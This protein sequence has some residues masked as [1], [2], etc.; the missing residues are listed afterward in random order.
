MT[1]SLLAITSLAV[2]VLLI[3][4]FLVYPTCVSP[5]SKIPAAH[6]TA[7][8]SPLWILWI[9]YTRGEVQTIHEAHRKFGPLVRLGPNEVSINCVDGGLRT[10]YAGAFDKPFFYDQF[11][12]YGISNMFS[13][14]ESKPHAARK[15]L[16]SHVYSKSFVQSSPDLCDATRIILHHRLLPSLD[17]VAT[18]GL[19][20]EV[21]G[22]NYAVTMDFISSYL[23]GL[24]RENN[25]IRDVEMRKRF[26][27]WHFKRSEHAFWYQEIPRVTQWLQRIGLHLV[28]RWVDTANANI[29]SYVLHLCRAAE[30]S[31]QAASDHDH[32]KA[33]GTRPVVYSQLT[34]A[35][36][37]APVKAEGQKGGGG[38]EADELPVAS[39]MLDHL[40]A[41]MDTSAITLTY[42]LWEMSRHA[43]LQAS[44]RKEVCRLSP[45]LA[46]GNDSGLPSARSLDALPLLHAVVME[47]LRLHCPIPGSQP[48]QT[49]SKPTS[50]VGS[51]PL[52]GGVRVSAQA[53]SLHRNENVFS[54]AEAWVP[55]RWLDPP[56]ETKDE[57]ARWFWAFGSGGRMCVGSNFAMQELKYVTAAVYTNFTTT[58]VDDTGIEQEDG[59][60]TGPRGNQLT[61]KFTRA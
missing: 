51:P 12:N 9:R 60:T 48:R 10:V 22:L 17:S 6:L 2:V 49:P 52:P 5:L 46:I 21:L 44:V 39:E 19:S 1:S 50:I 61:L 7:S 31:I 33:H 55:Q 58:V 3:Y 32:E 30:Q 11:R 36:K 42:L 47:T 45:S 28:P 40:I 54:D 37:R 18:R 14:K 29:Q 56:P 24:S 25:F 8:W 15:R 41:G 35:L 59:Y 13:T 27:S 38:A 43:E 23:F 16:L 53:Y 57:M 34:D 4:K 26:L 20:L